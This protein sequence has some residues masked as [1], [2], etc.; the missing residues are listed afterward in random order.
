METVVQKSIA[1]P[2]APAATP[3]ADISSF[4]PATTG[5][6]QRYVQLLLLVLAAG[7]IYPLLYLRQ[8]Y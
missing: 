6:S 7:G 8:V 5:S 2:N 4:A 3:H 1:K